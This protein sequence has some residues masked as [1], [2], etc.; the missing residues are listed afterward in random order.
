APTALEPVNEMPRTAE[1]SSSGVP[2]L[3]P[4]PCT[5]LNTPGGSLAATAVSAR[6]D[7]TCADISDGLST[8][9]L[10]NASAGAAFQSGIASGKFHGVM[11]ATTPNGSCS[12]NCSAP[13]A[14][15]GITSPTA[16]TASPA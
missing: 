5:T 15:D 4:I 1:C 7:A 16:R 9:V 6:S 10:P 8:T 3:G 12:V 14:C 13:G 2:T 11:S